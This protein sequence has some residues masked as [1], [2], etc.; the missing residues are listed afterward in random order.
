MIFAKIIFFHEDKY[1]F[2]E[3]QFVILKLYKSLFSSFLTKKI[4][5]EVK[6]NKVF[7]REK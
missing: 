6:S 3:K 5:Y 2:E 7:K 4:K 1:F